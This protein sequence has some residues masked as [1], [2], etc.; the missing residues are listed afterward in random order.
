MLLAQARRLQAPKS[1][2]APARPSRLRL[3]FVTTYVLAYTLWGSVILAAAGVIALPLPTM[4]ALF[5]GGLAPTVSAV[6]AAAAES[7]MQGVRALMTM[8]VRWRVAPRWYAVAL[9]GPALVVLSGLGLG[10]A[11]GSPLPPAPPASA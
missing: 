8:L 10:L 3:F 7:G 6:W 5:L 2:P 4:V 1:E 9:V 11:V